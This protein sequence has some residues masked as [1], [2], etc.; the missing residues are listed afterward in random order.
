MDYFYLMLIRFVMHLRW[1]ANVGP[2][3]DSFTLGD[4]PQLSLS[5]KNGATAAAPGGQAGSAAAAAAAAGGAAAAVACKK[6]PSVWVL[7]SR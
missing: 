5:V 6:S 7:L 1:P 3:N 2:K 4:N